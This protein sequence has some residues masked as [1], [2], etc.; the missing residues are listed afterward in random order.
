MAVSDAQERGGPERAFGYHWH[1]MI[2]KAL[3]ICEIV[4]REQVE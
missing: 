4:L 2:H 1:K 3:G